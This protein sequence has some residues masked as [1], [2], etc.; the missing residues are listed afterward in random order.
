MA[1][2]GD[3]DALKN[4]RDCKLNTPDAVMRELDG[5]TYLCWTISPTYR[6]VLECTAGI[7][8]EANIFQMAESVGDNSTE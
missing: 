8:S 1:Q 7:I 6:C 3:M 4:R 2:V 5:K